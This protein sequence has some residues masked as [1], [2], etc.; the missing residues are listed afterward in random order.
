MWWQ[1]HA[2]E[3]SAQAVLQYNVNAWQWL[4]QDS[5]AA[6]VF[7]R[8]LINPL[9]NITAEANRLGEVEWGTGLRS[10]DGTHPV[11]TVNHQIVQADLNIMYSLLT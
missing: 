11:G 10:L 4:S 5:G 9:Y 3:Q 7:D 8:V 6:D 2:A 1:A